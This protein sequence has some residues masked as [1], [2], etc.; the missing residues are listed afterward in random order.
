L[1]DAFAPAQRVEMLVD[2]N[3]IPDAATVDLN[4]LR[5]PPIGN[6]LIEFRRADADIGGGFFA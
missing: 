3:S 4:R 2:G 5:H 6:Q 1:V